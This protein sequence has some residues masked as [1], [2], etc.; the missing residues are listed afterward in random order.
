V[1]TSSNAPKETKCVDGKDEHSS[2]G[3]PVIWAG[4]FITNKLNRVSMPTCA[5]CE[6]DDAVIRKT[7]QILEQDSIAITYFCLCCFMS[8]ET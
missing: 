8:L 1:G 5:E 4:M 2:L 7:I 3:K 6:T